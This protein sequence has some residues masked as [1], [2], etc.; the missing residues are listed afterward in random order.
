MASQNLKL[1]ALNFAPKR[2]PL[3]SSCIIAKP[4]DLSYSRY[5]A[6]AKPWSH[7]PTGVLSIG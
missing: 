1:V 4:R 6:K 7:S 5:M 2:R 3:P